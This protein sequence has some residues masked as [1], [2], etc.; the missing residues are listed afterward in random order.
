M[1]AVRREEAVLDALPQAVGVERIAEVRVRVAVV[2]PQRR[3][4]HADLECGLEIFQDLAPVALVAGAAAVALV[5]DDEVEE[6]SRELS[7]Q[8]RP[9]LVPR[10]RLVGREIHLAALDRLAF[11][12]PARIPEWREDLVLRVVDEDIAVGEIQNARP[13]M[14][15]RA[16][17]AR[18]PELAA[19]LKC[20]D[21]LAGARRKRQ[22]HTALALQD[23]LHRAVDRDLLVVA[24][25]LPGEV[26]IRSEDALL[27]F[28]GDSFSAFE[29]FPQLIGCRKRMYRSHLLSYALCA[30]ESDHSL[31]PDVAI[32]HVESIMLEA[33]VCV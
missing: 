27:D 33:A 8:A 18:I 29:T 30:I 11:D 14:L 5:H 28:L 6:V 23:R 17:P 24:G 20:D 12:L 7:V 26:V 32:A 13:A 16:V 10:D 1:H 21:R 4:G 15:A 2:L 25:R 22:Q 3:R 9:P 19:N 31:T